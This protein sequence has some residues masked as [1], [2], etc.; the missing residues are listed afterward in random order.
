MAIVLLIS[1][2]SAFAQ[3]PDRGWEWQNPLPQGNA[4]NAIRFAKDKL[5]GWAVG[6]DGVILYTSSGGFDWEAQHPRSATT[7]NGIYVQ[8]RRHA[9]A[10]GARGVVLMTTNGGQRWIRIETPTKDHLYSITFAEDD[11][12]RGWAVG[13]YGAVIA[14]TDGGRTWVMQ[15]A[16]TKVHL[17]AVSFCNRKEGL[18]VGDRGT[19]LLT[20]DG[21][22]T[23]KEEVRLGALP[24][25]G[26]SF[27]DQK[28]AVVV[29]FGG[30]VIVSDDG[31]ENWRISTQGLERAN[32]WM[33]WVLVHHPSDP[34]ALFCGMGD[35]SRGY[36]FD[37][38]IQGKGALYASR[39]RGDSWQPVMTDTPS[40]LT[41]WVA[42]N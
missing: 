37:A 20:K 24:F 15:P 36:G 31:G 39:D 4:I 32:P 13:S 16:A 12:A 14:T 8:N 33:P 26:V 10:V 1:G 23:W 18:A 19:I 25:T 7:L 28:R 35:G 42:A 40:I 21:G 27:I 17:F 11:P 30:R 2:T 9:F 5:H 41:A 6:S 3:G 29:G 22:Q 34:K 38:R